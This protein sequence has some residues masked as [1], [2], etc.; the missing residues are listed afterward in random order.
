MDDI[1]R[2]Q[3]PTFY[4]IYKCIT[5]INTS[6]GYRS[7]IIIPVHYIMQFSSSSHDKFPQFSIQ[8]RAGYPFSCTMQEEE[9]WQKLLE[10]YWR[11]SV[12][13]SI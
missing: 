9:T 11:N 2:D 10:V 5:L 7:K 12:V 13:M 1:L 3:K 6:S 8:F 4:G